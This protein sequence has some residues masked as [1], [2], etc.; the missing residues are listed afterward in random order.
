MCCVI[1][2]LMVFFSDVKA[3]VILTLVTDACYTGA[4]VKYG[5]KFQ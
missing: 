1:Y 5:I 2:L 3:K 4:A